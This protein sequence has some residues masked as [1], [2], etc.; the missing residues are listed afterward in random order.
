[1]VYNH[2]KPCQFNHQRVAWPSAQTRARGVPEVTTALPAMVGVGPA[3][4]EDCVSSYLWPSNK[5]HR[6]PPA[7]ARPNCSVQRCRPSRSSGCALGIGPHRAPCRRAGRRRGGGRPAT[8]RATLD[9]AI[10]RPPPEIRVT[11]NSANGPQNG[12]TIVHRP[13]L[14]GLVWSSGILPE[15]DTGHPS[16]SPSSGGVLRVGIVRAMHRMRFRS[17]SG[18]WMRRRPRSRAP[19]S[20]T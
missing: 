16:P 8:I 14:P 4:L 7:F 15:V 10:R 17:C 11:L 20:I 18:C 19:S 5:L 13:P 3:K 12:T 2:H 9:S 6:I 1:M